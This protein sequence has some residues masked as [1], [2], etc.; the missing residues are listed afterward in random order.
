[1]ARERM[2]TRTISTTTIE[3][4]VINIET[5]EVG[6]KHFVLGQNM[7]KDEKTM[8]NNAQAMLDI[9]TGNALWKCVDVKNVKEEEALYGMPES[10]FIKYANALPPR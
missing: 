10:E 6:T 9:E 1:M 8:L 7:I 2:I 3:V 5:S 4:L